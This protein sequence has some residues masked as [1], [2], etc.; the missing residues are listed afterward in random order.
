[1]YWPSQLA[2]SRAAPCWFSDYG[3][4][5]RSSAGVR[6]PQPTD[7]K[8]AVQICRLRGFTSYTGFLQTGRRGF[9]YKSP[10]RKTEIKSKARW[11]ERSCQVKAQCHKCDVQGWLLLMNTEGGGGF[12]FHLTKSTSAFWKEEEL[13]GTPLNPITVCLNTSWTYWTECVE[14]FLCSLAAGRPQHHNTWSSQ[15][16]FWLHVMVI[17]INVKPFTFIG[18]ESLLE[19]SK[20]GWFKIS[21]MSTKLFC[22]TKKDKIAML[23]QRF[24]FF[25]SSVTC[26][27]K[28]SKWNVD[29]LI[30]LFLLF[31][32]ANLE[33]KRK[34]DRG[35]KNTQRVARLSVLLWKNAVSFC[36]YGWYW[37]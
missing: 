37:P 4:W 19:L 1:M 8:G 3:L 29:L 27:K 17:K 2:Q 11:V 9:H 25:I 5:A 12:W 10:S 6:W 22:S 32:M 35:K 36:C 31:W 20:S 23:L 28:K 13:G 34:G 18:D 14:A 7:G 21:Q 26:K 16:V 15:R 30:Q 33:G 24:L